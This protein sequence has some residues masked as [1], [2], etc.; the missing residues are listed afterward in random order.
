MFWSVSIPFY[1]LLFVYCF[2]Y[3]FLKM[4]Y[5]CNMYMPHVVILFNWRNQKNKSGLYSIHI[6]IK[7][8]VNARYYKI[9]TPKKIRLEEWSGKEDG[10]VKPCHPFAFEINNK[11]IEK[12]AVLHELQYYQRPGNRGNSQTIIRTFREDHAG[13]VKCFH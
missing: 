10:W 11:I 8:G 7:I 4:D 3:G 5:I 2:V 13:Q 12:K 6:R 1:S 9:D